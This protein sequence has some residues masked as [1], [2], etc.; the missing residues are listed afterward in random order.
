VWNKVTRGNNWRPVWSPDGAHVATRYQ[1]RG[2]GTFDLETTSVATGSFTTLLEWN[3]GVTPL[4]W[5]R[6]GQTL[7]VNLRV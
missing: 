7:V 5:T 2:I 4:G 6:D 1:G 3:N